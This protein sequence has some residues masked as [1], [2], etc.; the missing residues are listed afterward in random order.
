VQKLG[1]EQA[2][3]SSA[4]EQTFKQAA[5]AATSETL[6]QLKV[7]ELVGDVTES[8]LKQV[9]DAATTAEQI[10]HRFALPLEKAQKLLSDTRTLLNR[11][12]GDAALKEA[13]ANPISARLRQVVGDG[14]ERPFKQRV[15][16]I[17]TESGEESWQ[18]TLK[19]A[20]ESEAKRQGKEV[21]QFTDEVVES[22]WKGAREGAEASV[23]RCVREGVEQGFKRF[24]EGK[25]RPGARVPAA[26]AVA[27][28]RG[29]EVDAEG[30]GESVEGE[31]LAGPGAAGGGAGSGS[32]EAGTKVE[33]YD[34]GN[35]M[36]RIVTMVFDRA[37]NRWVELSSVEAR[38]ERPENN[39][40][41]PGSPQQYKGQAPGSTAA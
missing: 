35:G 6:R 12:D 34:L 36:E 8:W 29:A 25:K 40:A 39:S 2:L 20:V 3:A 27:G 19:E 23:H 9:T 16:G 11:G 32:E 22:A 41:R 18:R 7:S 24:R 33:T 15:K 30:D 31:G 13:L 21:A 17:L 28:L 37:H 10:A 5:D 1:A 38:I 14:M 26:A 4:V